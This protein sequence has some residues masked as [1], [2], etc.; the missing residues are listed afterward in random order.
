MRNWTIIGLV[1]LAAV[2]DIALRFGRGQQLSEQDIEDI[3]HRYG[4]RVEWSDQKL[5]ED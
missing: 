1:G 5:E 4:C 2:I 3:A